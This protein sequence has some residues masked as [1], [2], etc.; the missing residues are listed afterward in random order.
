M[1]PRPE[2]KLWWKRTRPKKAKTPRLQRPKK[3]PTQRSSSLHLVVGLGN[4]GP[5]FL[6]TRHNVGFAVAEELAK[7]HSLR[8]RKAFL[9]PYLYA[10]DPKLFLSMPLTYMNRSGLVIPALLRKSRSKVSD[11]VVIVDNMDLPAGTVRMKRKG[12]SRSHNGLGSLMDVLQTG[13]FLRIYIGIG[14]PGRT[15][16]VVDHVLGVIS[17]AELPL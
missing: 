6:N 1:L 15:V 5:R 14:R 4:P 17:D 9:Q 12:A 8:F 2:L 3:S 7:T 16:S 13:E 11:L 10:R